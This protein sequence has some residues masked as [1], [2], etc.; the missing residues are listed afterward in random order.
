MLTVQLRFKKRQ[1]NKQLIL[2]LEKLRNGECTQ[3]YQL[4]VTNRFEQLERTSEPHTPDELR[5]QLKG[6]T[7]DAAKETLEKDYI[8][9]KNWISKHT[10][11]LITKKREA[12]GKSP[13]EYKRLRNEVQKMLRR[14]KQE[15]IESLC[16]ELEENAKKGNSRAVFK[17]VK[18]SN[19]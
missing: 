15:E 17:T 1:V 19:H 18:T 7:I 9:C 4:E 12:K 3:Q 10:F 16:S 11:E 2:N 8:R 14:D 5:Q 13:D 6:T